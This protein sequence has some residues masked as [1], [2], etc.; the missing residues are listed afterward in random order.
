MMKRQQIL[1]VQSMKMKFTFNTYEVN[2]E[3]GTTTKLVNGRIVT[4]KTEKNINLKTE[5]NDRIYKN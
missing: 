2:W 5:Q 4:V 3:D 1:Q